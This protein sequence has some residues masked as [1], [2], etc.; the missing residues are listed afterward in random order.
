MTQS[1][2]APAAHAASSMHNNN[3]DNCIIKPANRLSVVDCHD[4][5]RSPI[6]NCSG[7][8]INLAYAMESKQCCQFS[9]L[10]AR[11]VCL[12]VADASENSRV[13]FLFSQFGSTVSNVI[14]VARLIYQLSITRDGCVIG[15][16][17]T[18]VIHL[19][20]DNIS[21]APLQLELP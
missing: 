14:F 19:S 15:Y 8:S 1:P 7:N 6:V 12:Q 10:S 2:S 21:H 5:C 18:I 20:I 3:S 9:Y 16:D 11:Y 17:D 13:F 4:D